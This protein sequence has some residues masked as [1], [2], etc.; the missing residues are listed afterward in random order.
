MRA[1]GSFGGKVGLAAQAARGRTLL[2][3]A[4]FLRALTAE[5]RGANLIQRTQTVCLRNHGVASQWRL[6]LQSPTSCTHS[7]RPRYQRTGFTVQTMEAKPGDN[8]IAARIGSAA[9]S[10]FQ[11]LLS[12]R[13]TR[14]K[15]T[16]LMGL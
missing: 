6:L 4:V 14:I 1:C 2:V 7:L 12:I 9:H 11:T 15:P 8:S 10:T 16:T 5:H 13:K 3:A